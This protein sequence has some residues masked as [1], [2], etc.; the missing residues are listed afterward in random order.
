MLIIGCSAVSSFS[1]VLAIHATASSSDCLGLWL[2]ESWNYFW[3]VNV[4]KPSIFSKRTV[5][6]KHKQT[7]EKL[8][9]ISDS[10]WD[11]NKHCVFRD[12]GKNYEC[13]HLILR[14]Y[15]CMCSSSADSN[16]M[17]ICM[18]QNCFSVSQYI[19][20]IFQCV[21]KAAWEWPPFMHGEDWAQ[22]AESYLHCTAHM[23]RFQLRRLPWQT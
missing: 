16:N 21:S 10:L 15:L 3:I 20:E 19:N 8:F 7:N 22:E 6:L 1:E 9:G 18:Q 2:S 4:D 12:M 23:L 17:Q 14:H 13:C 5:S 11:C